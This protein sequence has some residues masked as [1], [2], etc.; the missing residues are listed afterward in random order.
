MHDP[1]VGNV[2]VFSPS[3]I[4]IACAYN[5]PGEFIDSQITE[6]GQVYL[7]LEACQEKTGGLCVVDSVFVRGQYQFLIKSAEDH[8]IEGNNDEGIIEFRQ[9]M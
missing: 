1:Y 9:A 3:G 5:A 8:L 6:C 2:F 7:N 4:I